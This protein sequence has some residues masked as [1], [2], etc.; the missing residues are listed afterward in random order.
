MW[1]A[2][3]SDLQ[4]GLLIAPIDIPH[5]SWNVSIK[6]ATLV[7]TPDHGTGDLF[8][9][10]ATGLTIPYTAFPGNDA[11]SRFEF[12][13]PGRRAIVLFWKTSEDI[14]DGKLGVPLLW[15]AVA[16]PEGTE[17][18]IAFGL[19]S[20][21]QLMFDRYAIAEGHFKDGKSTGK[22]YWRGLS[23]RG[24]ASNIGQLVCNKAGGELPVDWPYVNEKHVRKGSENDKTFELAISA[25]DVANNRAQ[26]LFDD[27]SAGEDGVD[28]QWR[29]YVTDDNQH[30]RCR[31]IA[32]TDQEH[33]IGQKAR[34][35]FSYSPQGG[36]AENVKVTFSSPTQRVYGTG[37]GSDAAVL[38]AMSED[39]TLVTKRDGYSL[40]EQSISNTDV[41]N[42]S[43]LKSLTSGQLNA[44][45]KPHMQISWDY[46]M[47]DEHVPTVGSFWPG[48]SVN[49][50][51]RGHPW[52][53]DGTYTLRAMEF[54]GD[55][56][57]RVHVLTDVVENPFA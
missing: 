40:V 23:K 53:A 47:N 1:Q 9:Q 50:Y 49:L 20:V 57:G 34:Y 22:Q 51:T 45:R 28:M 36:T 56:S 2:Y 33:F 11:R 25:W 6:D 52:L 30:V 44:S 32:G 16:G 7:T 29:P 35:S 21:Y 24:L 41:N 14:R 42:I 5:F 37:S 54:S 38:T 13:E 3:V 4:S 15:G 8:A 19:S 27:L 39:L 12:I 26:K 43:V 55:T 46:F 17:K 18:D 10:N 31:F 48:E